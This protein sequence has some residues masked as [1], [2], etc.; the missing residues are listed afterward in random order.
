[1]RGVLLLGM[2]MALAGCDQD[3]RLVHLSQCREAVVN[4]QQG[5]PPAPGSLVEQCMLQLGYSY[6][7]DHPLCQ[8]LQGMEFGA[9][10]L[11][12]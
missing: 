8:T 9:C 1:M 5:P 4:R 10:Y 12:R 11:E 6:R 7:G 3:N 2:A